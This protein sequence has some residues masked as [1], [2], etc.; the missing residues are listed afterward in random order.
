MGIIIHCERDDICL[1]GTPGTSQLIIRFFNNETPAD[2][3]PVPFLIIKEINKNDDEY[4]RRYL[5]PIDSIAFPLNPLENKT[6]L[7][8][9]YNWAG[10][11]EKRDT[12]SFEY[13]RTDIYINRACGFKGEYILNNQALKGI[14]KENSWIKS[15]QII[16]D[17]II[18]ETSMHMALYH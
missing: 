12:L 1:E 8:F 5:L 6:N 7:I 18:D 11:D 16:K 10:N 3:K 15:Y 13:N 4:L 14:G 2:Y 17:S 9:I